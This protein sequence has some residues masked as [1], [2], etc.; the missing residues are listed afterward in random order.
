MRPAEQINYRDYRNP[1]YNRAV[2]LMRG[3]RY[4]PS[5]ELEAVEEADAVYRQ[6]LRNLPSSTGAL[7]NRL[8]SAATRRYKQRGD[9]FTKAQNV[10]LGLRGEEA[11]FRAGLGAQDVATR[12]N[13]EDIN[14]RNRAM[15]RSHL[16]E[17]MTNMQ[18]IALQN[19]L[20]RNQQQRDERLYGLADSML[21]NYEFDPNTYRFNFRQKVE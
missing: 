10:N 14:A 16:A 7:Q 19:R 12:F 9:V 11:K 5:A 20:M 21:Y 18:Q 3:R 1:E 2:S 15:R 17:S 8:A 6:Q 4:D 13:V